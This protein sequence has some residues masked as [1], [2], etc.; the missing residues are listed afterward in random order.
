MKNKKKVEKEE[1]KNLQINMPTGG[2]MM[3]PKRKM[4]Q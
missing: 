4:K 3:M 2:R 1:N